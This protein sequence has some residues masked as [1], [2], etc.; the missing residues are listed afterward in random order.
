MTKK[1]ETPIL[2]LTENNIAAD[3]K[4]KRMNKIANFD[5]VADSLGPHED[6]LKRNFFDNH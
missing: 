4:I 5:F 1:T 6:L 3:D 2:N